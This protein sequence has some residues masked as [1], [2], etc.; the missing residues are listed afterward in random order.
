MR[1][2]TFLPSAL[3]FPLYLISLITRG[4]GVERIVNPVLSADY[5]YAGVV[6]G[7]CH[8]TDHLQVLLNKACTFV[9]GLGH[10][11]SSF[12]GKTRVPKMKL[13]GF[14]ARILSAPSHQVAYCV[15]FTMHDT[16]V[17]ARANDAILAMPNDATVNVHGS[18]GCLFHTSWS[19]AGAGTALL[20][21]ATRSER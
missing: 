1:I 21:W 7:E 8:G 20:R 13:D 11:Q 6:Y 19:A 3:V 12:Q 17:E 10:D 16:V 4:V 18:P 9:A 14:Q 15:H 5:A 2:S